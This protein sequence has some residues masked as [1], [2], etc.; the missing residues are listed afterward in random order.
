MIRSLGAALLVVGVVATGAPG[1]GP[2]P[3]SPWLTGK[4]LVATERLGDP[5][6]VRTV[7]YMLQHDAHGAMGLVVNR[8]LGAVPLAHVLAQFGLD[9]TGVHGDIPI[10]YGGP[11]EPRRGFVLHTSDFPGTEVIGDGIALSVGRGILAAIAHGRGPRRSRLTFGYAGWAPGQL[12]AEMGAGAWFTVPA[13]E[14][15]L[16]DT[17]DDVKW[18][19]ARARR[20][21]TL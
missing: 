6:F 3:G 18:E 5:R 7:I 2:G 20:T 21:I 8:S 15:L 13:D 1:A 16:F 4:L 19:H 10:H 17:D 9:A 11:V 14:T 12:E